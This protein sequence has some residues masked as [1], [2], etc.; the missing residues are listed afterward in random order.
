[1]ELHSSRFLDF[2]PELRLMVYENLPRS[3]KHYRLNQKYPHHGRDVQSSLIFITRSEPMS[4]LATCRLVNKEAGPI[5]VQ[6]ADSFVRAGIPKTMVTYGE[7][8]AAI[9]TLGCLFQDMQ[10]HFKHNV[11]IFEDTDTVLRQFLEDQ[12]SLTT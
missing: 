11:P 1:M 3:I 5:V 10:D 4:V 12:L 7:H 8:S 6:L 2:P 9:C